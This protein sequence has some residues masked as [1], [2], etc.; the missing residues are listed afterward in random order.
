MKKLLLMI[1]L[2]L[3]L[4][5]CSSTSGLHK[6]NNDELSKKTEDLAFNPQLPT[7]LP[8]ELERAEFSHPPKVQQPYK[9]L[10]FD[11]YG[12]TKE[13]LSL[14][15]INGG[16]VSSTSQEEY[17][18]VQVE[19][20]YGKYFVDSSGNKTLRWAEGKIHYVLKYF[21]EQSETKVEKNDLIEAAESF[22]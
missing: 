20:K 8:F 10:T 11:F 13:H 1:T 6:F 19:D 15:T 17:Q 14:L 2:P 4:V 7:E 16:E 18:D 9:T 5:A 21:A 22:Q 12:E 3:I